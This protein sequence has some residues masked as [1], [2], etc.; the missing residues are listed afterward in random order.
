M[1]RTDSTGSTWR[2]RWAR[3]QNERRLRLFRSAE[4]TWRRRDDELRR[5]RTLAEQCQGSATAGDGLPLE[6]APGEVVLRVVPAAQLVEMRH[7]AVLPAPDLTVGAQTGR[8][9]RR[10]PD[11]VRVTDAGMAVVTNRRLVLLGGRGRRDWAYGRMTGLNHDPHASVTLIQVLDR[12]RTSGVL[13]RPDV[14]AEFRFVLTLAFADAIEQRQAVIDQLDELIDEHAR[15]RPSRP[16]I[17]T[18]GQAR[19]LALI[20]GGRRTAV[21]AAALAVMVPVALANSGPSDPTSTETAVAATGAP[22]ATSTSTAARGTGSTAAPRST[23][24]STASPKPERRC[25]APK[26]PMGYDFCGGKRVRE[27]AREVCDH[28]DCVPGFWEGR[29]YLVQCENGKVSLAGGS[30][31]ACGLHGGVRRT[32][33]D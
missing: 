10:L 1:A 7:N 20:P 4:G 6:L 17:A 32:V 3:R 26:N 19:L 25:G 12:R 27:P 30:P 8:L 33:W 16:G 18:P 24:T 11:G 15:L 5:L 13:L 21:V 29:G 23:D 9:R 2:Y 22:A 28:F 31:R 14:A